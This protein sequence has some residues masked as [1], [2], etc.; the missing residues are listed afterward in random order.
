MLVTAKTKLI[1]PWNGEVEG[2]KTG[3][4]ANKPV[5]TIRK[6]FS[7]GRTRGKSSVKPQN[8][9]LRLGKWCLAYVMIALNHWAVVL[10]PKL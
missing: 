7:S 1:A 2:V 3:S 5:G 6:T 10:N 9:A 4:S 8:R